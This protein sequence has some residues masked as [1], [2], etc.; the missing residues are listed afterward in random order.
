[1]FTH[2]HYFLGLAIEGMHPATSLLGALVLA[3]CFLVASLWSRFPQAAR[4]WAVIGAAVAILAAAWMGPIFDNDEAEHLHVAWLMSEGQLPYRDFWQ[5]HTPLLWLGLA[6]VLRA[7]PPSA[8]VCDFARLLALLVTV[9][10]G[11]L[12]LA[13]ARRVHGTVNIAAPAAMLWLAAVIPGESYNLRPDLFANAL[14]LGAL[15]VYLQPGLSLSALG[16]GILLGLA[17]TFCPKHLLLLA[18]LPAIVVWERKSSAH[19]VRWGILYCL[20]LV[21]GIAPLGLW[22][23][24]RGLLNAFHYWVFSFNATQKGLIIGGTLPLLPLM[25]VGWWSW[26][27]FSNRSAPLTRAER[28]GF[29]A[30]VM[31]SLMFLVQPGEVKFT[32]NLQMFFLLL[33][34]VA[35]GETKKILAFVQARWG[36]GLAGVLIGLYF[37]PTILP[38]ATA[39]RNGDYLASRA[40]IGALIRASEGHTV[41]G[42]GRQHPLFARDAVDL[43]VLWQWF[44]LDKSEI[45]AGLRGMTDKII[46]ERPSLVIC[47]EETH[48]PD[49]AEAA[50]AAIAINATAR[51]A[52]SRAVPILAG[53]ST[54][55]TSSPMAAI[56]ADRSFHQ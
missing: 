46:R 24:E 40:E 27:M 38:L 14:A 50:G 10:S 45:Q 39:L 56:S 8:Y 23:A 55:S 28:V 49:A 9:L 41:V 32:Y 11:V 16:S 37:M 35:A 52:L 34:V 51:T 2:G 43:Y 44:W 36:P 48:P 30:L 19:A 31:A 29:V 47:F 18:V 42:I 54:I 4:R 6:P 53:L 26:R 7:M 33:A 3:S 1:M 12:V 20:G 25:L 22:L 13:L 21:V 15:L 17:V 5:H